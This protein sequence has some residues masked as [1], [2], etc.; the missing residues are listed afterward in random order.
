M[1]ILPSAISRS[2]VTVGLSR[3][4]I[5][6]VAL[7]QLPGAIGRGECELET[8]GDVLQAIFDGDAGHVVLQGRSVI[9]SAAIRARTGDTDRN[10]PRFDGGRSRPSARAAPGT[11]STDVDPQLSEQV[12][13][14]EGL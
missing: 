3:V 6:A 9:Q 7:G 8:V 2:A 13:V 5:F 4:S 12:G 10:M 11:D 1:P 14:A